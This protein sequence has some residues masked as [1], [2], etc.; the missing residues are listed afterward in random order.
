VDQSIHLLH[1]DTYFFVVP[2]VQCLMLWLD[3]QD[4]D[5]PDQC[6]LSCG[7]GVRDSKDEECDDGNLSEELDGCNSVCTRVCMC[8]C[9]YVCVC[10][11]A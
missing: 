1:K 6:F 10:V 5:S 8:V 9:V 7:D 2:C 3:W 11:F 4:L